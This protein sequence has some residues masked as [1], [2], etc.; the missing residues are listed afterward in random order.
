MIFFFF[1]SIPQCL[2]CLLYLF[3]VLFIMLYCSTCVLYFSFVHIYVIDTFVF[4]CGC[5]PYCFHSCLFSSFMWCF[6]LL[7]AHAS[8]LHSFI[9]F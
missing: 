1:V 2:T 6:L 7:L 3:A 5:F 4:F 8:F 9:N